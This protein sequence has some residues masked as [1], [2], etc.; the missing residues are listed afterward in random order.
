MYGSTGQIASSDPPLIVARGLTAHDLSEE[1]ACA[2]STI[3]EDY[4]EDVEEL[5][6]TGVAMKADYMTPAE[7]DKETQ[8][9]NRALSDDG[10]D[11]EM[12]IGWIVHRDRPHNLTQARTV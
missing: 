2:L 11:F 3:V 7:R 8:D 9:M 1:L 6:R 10:L 5:R 4:Y 12:V